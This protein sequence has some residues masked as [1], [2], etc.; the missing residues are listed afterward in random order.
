MPFLMLKLHSICIAITC[1]SIEIHSCHITQ[2]RL[3]TI[4]FIVTNVNLKV[5][6]TVKG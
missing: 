3:E 4:D 5:T 2:A 6:A 1:L